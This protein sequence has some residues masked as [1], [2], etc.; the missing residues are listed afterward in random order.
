MA[1][2]VHCR[3]VGRECDFVARAVTEDE[4]IDEMVKHLLRMHLVKELS[5]ADREQLRS[6][7][8]DEGRPADE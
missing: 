1:K 2:I 4:L 6:V 5:P 7:I 8:R 3:D